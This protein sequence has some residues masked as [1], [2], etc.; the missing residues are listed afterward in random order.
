MGAPKSKEGLPLFFATKSFADQ[1]RSFVT[2]DY[3]KRQSWYY[4]VTKVVDEVASTVDN[5]N[6]DFALA[7]TIIHLKWVTDRNE[8]ADRGVFVKVNDVAQTTGFSIIYNTSGKSTIAFSSPRDPSDV[9]KVS[10]STP[11][12]SLFELVSSPGKVLRVNYV[13]SQ[14]SAGAVLNDTMRYEL[15]LNTPLT[16]NTDVVVGSVEY[17]TAADY[18]NKADL[19]VVTPPFGEL[20]RD[21]ITFP[22]NYQTGFIIKPVGDPTTDPTKG[23]FNKVKI[24][25]KN[26]EPVTNCDIATGTIFCLVEDT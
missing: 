4:D 1:S 21:V 20:T 18:Y 23:E 22:W 24:F 26:D 19:G 25:L 3:C 16:G 6:F 13:E 12:S 10:Y 14:F 2:P 15:I 8:Y 11:N 5:T 17:Q 9:I 7:K